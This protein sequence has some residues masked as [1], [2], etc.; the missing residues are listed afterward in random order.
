MSIRGPLVEGGV[1]PSGPF[2]G[3]SPGSDAV[4][5]SPGSGEG[6]VCAPCWKIQIWLENPDLAQPGLARRGSRTQTF[7]DARLGRCSPRGSAPRP[8]G[9]IPPSRLRL[10]GSFPSLRGRN[11]PRQA[12]P[13]RP[14]ELQKPA[15]GA[16]GPPAGRSEDPAAR[17]GR[18][19]TPESESNYNPNYELHREGIPYRVYGYQRIPPLIKQ[20]PTKIR[21]TPVSLGVKSSRSP[22]KASRN[23][24]L[25]PRQ[26]KLHT[27]ELHSI[28]E[29]LSQIR[30][31]VDGLLESLQ[32]I[33]QQRDQSTGEEASI[34]QGGQPR[35]DG[36]PSR[37]I[38]STGFLFGCPSAAPK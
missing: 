10:R 33:D 36:N 26:I 5:T 18:A 13:G 27:A 7:S 12:F 24:H 4:C 32:H 30:A 20:V 2:M 31:Q 35:G 22:Y 21:R 15:V 23:S 6:P 8:R 37:T 17:A 34:S 28:W 16:A 14:P 11:Q 25:P 19:G 9:G 29:A 38:S 3:I 1:P